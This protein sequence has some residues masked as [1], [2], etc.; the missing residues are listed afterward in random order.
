MTVIGA[1]LSMAAVGA[2]GLDAAAAREVHR[3]HSA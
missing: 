2:G 1:L 3:P